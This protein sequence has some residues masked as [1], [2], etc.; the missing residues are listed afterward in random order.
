MSVPFYS[1]KKQEWPVTGST[2]LHLVDPARHPPRNRPA[3]IYTTALASS[4]STLPPPTI[5]NGARLTLLDRK[6]MPDIPLVNHNPRPSSH[7]PPPDE[8]IPHLPRHP[9]ILAP[10]EHVKP[11]SALLRRFPQLLLPLLLPNHPH[12]VQPHVYALP[13]AVPALEPPGARAGRRRR[14]AADACKVPREEGAREEGEEQRG[15]LLRVEREEGQ[16]LEQRDHAPAGRFGDVRHRRKQQKPTLQPQPGRPPRIPQ[17]PVEHL[18]RDE[19]PHRVSH[20]H[21]RI[22]PLALVRPQRRHVLV[23]SLDLPLHVPRLVLRREGRVLVVLEPQQAAPVEVVRRACRG[24]RLDRVEQPAEA[25]EEV[26]VEGDDPRVAADEVHERV[27]PR[28][29][30][31]RGGEV[32]DRRHGSP[33]DQC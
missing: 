12:L 2:L 23:H 31:V 32:Q 8:R 10:V 22:I 6:R 28:S 16:A 7:P 17:M 30:R 5:T 33:H 24:A 11:R 1:Y 19:R 29:A 15:D 4:H 13:H 14:E 26:L 9:V 18:D 3:V 25:V 21:H 27:L 20:Q